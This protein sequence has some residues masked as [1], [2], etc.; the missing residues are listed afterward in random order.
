[1]YDK[2]MQELL[3]RKSKNA[4]FAQ[5]LSQAQSLESSFSMSYKDN[6][7]SEQFLARMT[8][9][10]KRD[11]Q[12]IRDKFNQIVLQG[13]ETQVGLYFEQ[14]NKQYLIAHRLDMV[15]IPQFRVK[16]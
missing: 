6:K 16:Q 4:I 10:V 12:T 5:L 11:L 1:M 7:E 15:Q 2:F 13:I 14:D 9:D 8:S 3:K